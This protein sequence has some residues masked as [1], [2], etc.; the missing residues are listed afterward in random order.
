MTPFENFQKNFERYLRYNVNCIC[1]LQSSVD[2]ELAH[3]KKQHATYAFIIG[4]E[5]Q[6]MGFTIWAV[7]IPSGDLNSNELLIYELFGRQKA[8]AIDLVPTTFIFIQ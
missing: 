2:E 4:L 8:T 7:Y 3:F 6:I 5:A 1:Q